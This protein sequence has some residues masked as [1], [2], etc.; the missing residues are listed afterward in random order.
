MFYAL[1]LDPV[2]DFALPLRSGITAYIQKD[3]DEVGYLLR[4]YLKHMS[5]PVRDGSALAV[6]IHQEYLKGSLDFIW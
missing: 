3:V 6:V 4:R 5:R 2:S 1:P